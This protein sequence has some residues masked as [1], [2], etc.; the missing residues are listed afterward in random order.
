MP[1]GNSEGLDAPAAGRSRT[2]S[3]WHAQAVDGP[4]L[5]HVVSHG[6]PSPPLPPTGPARYT[7]RRKTRNARGRLP[8]ARTAP[9]PDWQTSPTLAGDLARP[10]RLRG[11][12]VM[13]LQEFRGILDDIR[14]DRIRSWPDVHKALEE[15]CRVWPARKQRHA[16]ALPLEMLGEEQRV[17][18][19]WQ[20]ALGEAERIQRLICDRV[21][22]SRKKDDTDPFR[23]MTF[24]SEQEM[25]TVVGS[26]ESS[27]FVRGTRRETDEFSRRVVAAPTGIGGD[28]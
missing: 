24:D 28:D 26:T 2:R 21:F 1:R 18:T 4:G 15:R 7:P 3:T 10:D 27:D 19:T 20:E 6:V 5:G 13:R 9:T 25:Q 14:S 23:R 22:A 8:M 11:G 12:Q 17:A 16:P